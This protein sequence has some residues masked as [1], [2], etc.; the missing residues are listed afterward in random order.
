MRSRFGSRHAALAALIYCAIAGYGGAFQHPEVFPFFN[1]SLFSTPPKVVED[2]SVKISRVNGRELEQ[3]QWI[4]YMPQRFPGYGIS[5]SKQLLE[6]GQ[7]LTRGDAAGAT[8]QR[9]LFENLFAGLDSV[10][11]TLY[12]RRAQPLVRWH[13]DQF[14]ALE[15]VGTFRWTQ[16][17]RARSE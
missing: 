17:V 4:E 13:T 3:A 15:A 16:P 2:W 10:E 12:R 9:Q 1:W 11:Y 7:R 5:Q 6:W 14:D 8:L